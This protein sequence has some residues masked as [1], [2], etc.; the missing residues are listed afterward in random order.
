[1]DLAKP[2]LDVGLF[3]NRI[4][5]MRAFYGERLGLQYETVLPLGG[6]MRQHRYLASGSVI[7]LNHSRNPL[8]ARTPGGYA[9]IIIAA[10]TV[11][12]PQPLRDPDGNSLTLVPLGHNGIRGIAIELGV[13]DESAFERFYVGAMD[14][15]RLEPG[16]V[17]LGDTVICFAH[18]PAARPAA[19]ATPA[20][21]P[22]EVVSGMAALGI[23]YFTVQVLD[24]NAAY[25]RLVAAGVRQAMAP[26][27]F[28]ALARICF[29][30]DP[31]G[32]VIEISQRAAEGRP[33]PLD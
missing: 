30:R 10:A 23:R 15:A 28:G 11:P 3:T 21:T 17:K 32:N 4:D 1:M 25:R 16:R 22:L 24:C 6:G 14:C 8:P 9:G 31:D 13:T 18:D 7:K 26:I 2:R 27:N 12:A 33:L 20:K 5:E 29:V 19:E